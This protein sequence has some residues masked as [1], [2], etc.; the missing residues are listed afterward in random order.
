MAA[1]AGAMLVPFYLINPF[2]GYD[3]MLKAF[4]ISI[5]GGLGS[6]PG[7]V[8]A[9]LI[10]G[11]V[12][13][14]GGFYLTASY[15]TAM[16]FGLS[17]T[18]AAAASGGP[19]GVVSLMKTPAGDDR[20]ASLLKIALVAATI[21]IAA[22]FPLFARQQ[23]VV[24]GILILFNCYLAQCW[25]L[26]AG[27]AG[28]FSLGH[29]IF[30]ATGAYASTVL[31]RDYGISPWIGMWAGA[32]IAAALGAALSAVAFWYRVRGVFFAVITLSAV[33]VFRGLCS[34]WEFLGGTS[35]IFLISANDPANMN[36]L[37]R[38][39]YYEIILGMVVLAGLGTLWLERSRFGQ[40]L[41]A[42]REDEDAAEASGV[43]TFRCKVMIIAIS[44]AATALAGTFYAQFLLFIVPETLFTFDHVLNM[45]LGTIVGGSGTVIGPIVGSALFGLFGDV[46]RAL[47]FVSSR[48]AASLVRVGYGLVL[49]VLV[50]RLPRGIV[51]LWRWRS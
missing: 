4:V 35:G 3:F 26:A 23:W 25:N 14:L 18:H 36:F 43:P 31:F 50:L 33:E 48:E 42:L 7:A 24:A 28:Q 10:I 13:A 19:H 34:G 16:V 2:V 41:M 8:L 1:F 20:T 21:V 17:D 15:A 40:Y 5:I 44:A 38:V 6:L 46:L 37:S 51:G 12:E 29:T 30:L 49:V 27:Y 11:V 45:M 22:L 9:G 32:L 39:P 47:P